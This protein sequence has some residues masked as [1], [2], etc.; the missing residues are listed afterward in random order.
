MEKSKL[1]SVEPIITN[2]VH[3][4]W[5]NDKGKYFKYKLE[6]ENGM[7][8]SSLGKNNTPSWRTGEEYEFEVKES[9][10][11]KSFSKIKST[12]APVFGGAPKKSPYFPYDTPKEWALDVARKLEN[13]KLGI[14]INGIAYQSKPD[15]IIATA[16][17]IVKLL[18]SYN[19][20]AITNAFTCAAAEAM[21]NKNV[22][23]AKQILEDIKLYNEFLR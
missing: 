9:S 5:E 1:K 18:D 12:S 14:E 11:Y 15:V 16:R 17:W 4:T 19:R 23:E 3:Q 6:W 20:H 2:G 10:G 13:S 8:G 22:V 21:N 7:V